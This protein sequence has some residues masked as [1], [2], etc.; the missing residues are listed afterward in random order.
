MI[1]ILPMPAKK[2]TVDQ[3]CQMLLDDVRQIDCTLNNPKTPASDKDNLWQRKTE[4]LTIVN[5][6]TKASL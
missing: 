5:L 6:F 4:K 3:Y 2:I 1:P